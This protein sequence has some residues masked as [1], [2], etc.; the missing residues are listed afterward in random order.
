MKTQKKLLLILVLV[1]LSA[2]DTP[3]W[4]HSQN[5]P[6]STATS[7]QV[8]TS[9]LALVTPTV[10]ATPPAP[11]LDNLSSTVQ[12]PTP[13]LAPD[14]WKSMP[15]IPVVSTRM[16]AVY[17]AGLAAGRDPNKFSKIGDCQ[18]ISTYFLSSFDNPK[19]YTLGSQYAFLQPTIDHFAG[20]WSRSSL[21][22]RGGEN[23]ASALTPF[24]ADPKKCNAGE[25]PIACEIRINN[26]SIV[27]ISFEESWNGNLVVYNED[28]RKVVEYILSQN[29]VPILATRAEN[30]GSANSI[31]E[32]VARIAYDYQVPLWN[33]WAATNPLPSHGL[34]VDGFHLTQGRDLFNFNDPSDMKEGWPWRNLTALEAIDA[35]YRGV[36][37]QH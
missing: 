26:P 34:V 1:F 23:V 18:N 7:T 21:A 30:P 36:S 22:T 28:L 5:V 32:V 33:F 17:K 13:T 6:I 8:P 25:T 24:W 9:T 31:N 29:V 2:C 11:T 37:G 19:D 20:S 10:L 35:V 3:E 15:I 27:T 16:I 12:A 14:A 4:G